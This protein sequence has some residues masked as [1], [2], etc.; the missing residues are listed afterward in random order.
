VSKY[1]TKLKR[2]DNKKKAKVILDRNDLLE[3]YIRPMQNRL[4][5][6][7]VMLDNQMSVW[8]NNSS[9]ELSQGCQ[10]CREGTA[11]SLFPGMKCNLDCSYCP[12]GDKSQRN[13]SLNHD[14]A[15]V[16]D[17]MT[18]LWID[19]LKLMIKDASDN[20]LKGIS[21]SGGEPFLYLNKV[22]EMGNF[23]KE[24]KPNC[25]QWLYTNGV[26]ADRTNLT[27]VFNANIDEIRF[28][29]SASN[30][31]D[32]VMDHLKI[33]REIF[34]RVTVEIPTTEK[35]REWMIDKDGLEILEKIGIEQLNLGELFYLPNDPRQDFS[36][37][38][39]YPFTQFPFP[40]RISEVKSRVYTYEIIEAAINRN[41]D[42]LINDCSNERKVVQMVKRL[43]NPY[44]FWRF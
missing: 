20:K 14:R 10:C 41:I 43:S 13:S 34:S 25:Y 27:R 31:D 8:T 15:F 18:L 28:H 6:H 22:V 32:K 19:D 16:I 37:D 2:P 7:L 3:E 9:Y 38:R 4:K 23:I 30:F 17:P 24:K 40:T 11:I 5:D 21:Y 35:V 44:F 33:A 29:I 36:S 42:I 12:Q 1:L 39:F 26:L